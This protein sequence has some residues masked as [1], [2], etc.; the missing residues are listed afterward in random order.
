MCL[1]LNFV[2]S[3]LALHSRSAMVEQEKESYITT[4]NKNTCTNNLT[5]SLFFLLECVCVVSLH[6]LLLTCFSFL[7]LVTFSGVYSYGIWHLVFGISFSSYAFQL[8]FAS[9]SMKRVRNNKI[10]CS[11]KAN[12]MLKLHILY[13]MP[14]FSESVHFFIFVA[15]I[16][17]N[18]FSLC[19]WKIFEWLW[20]NKR[21]TNSE[22]EEKEKKN[23]KILKQKYVIYFVILLLLSFSNK[24]VGRHES[25]VH[26]YMRKQKYMKSSEK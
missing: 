24:E 1:L 14:F 16:F 3:V 11:H 26:F 23:N 10:F 5:I 22:K 19:V 2:L 6:F 17:S 12:T 21:Q 18:F 20:W 15:C 8:L 4:S 9:F 7:F 25:K 13:V